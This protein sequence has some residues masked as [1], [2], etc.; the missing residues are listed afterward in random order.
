MKKIRSLN[1]LVAGCLLLS[2]SH[3]E[4]KNAS[5]ASQNSIDKAAWILGE[6]QNVSSEGAVYEHWQKLNDSTFAGEG[7]FVRGN[8]TLSKE[9]LALE[10]H[11]SDLFY[12]PTVNNQNE[13]KAVN[14]KLTSSSESELIFE[15][16]THDFP[17][18][19]TYNKISPDSIVAKISGSVEGQERAEEFPL[20]RAK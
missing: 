7:L 18:K 9:Q 10:Q 17:Q 13:G 3:E 6:W 5:N 12:I 15:N 8:D 14:F 4:S 11:G 19:I 16:P 2:C 20:K 1:L